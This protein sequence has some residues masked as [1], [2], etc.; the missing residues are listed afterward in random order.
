MN[1]LE[2]RGAAWAEHRGTSDGERR[3]LTGAWQASG[4]QS[5]CRTGWC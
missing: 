1:E 2:G 3:A 5:L 4:E